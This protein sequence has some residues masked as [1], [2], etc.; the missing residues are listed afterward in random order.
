M[1]VSKC[2]HCGEHYSTGKGYFMHMRV[3]IVLNKKPAKDF[4][5]WF[6]SIKAYIERRLSDNG[7]NNG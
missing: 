1:S 6:S 4:V 5:S 3:C 2:M 7:N